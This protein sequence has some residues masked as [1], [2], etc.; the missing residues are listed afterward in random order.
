MRFQRDTK[1][2]DAPTLRGWSMKITFQ[3]AFEQTRY[4]ACM[5]GRSS[6]VFALHLRVCG[7]K[8]GRVM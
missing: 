7:I 1:A 6:A 2:S 5:R 4:F 3:S 8:R